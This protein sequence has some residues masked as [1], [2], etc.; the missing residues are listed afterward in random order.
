[1]ELFD[2]MVA[3]DY[4]QKPSISEI[5]QSAWMKEINWELMP[6]LKEEFI[7]R[8][9][10][11]YTNISRQNALKKNNYISNE[12]RTNKFK[13]NTS[14]E[15][16]K[17]PY[18]IS[19]YSENN[20]IKK[21]DGSIRIKTSNKNLANILNNIK[22][23]LQNEGYIKFGGNIKKNEYE[24]TNGDYDFFLFLRKYKK[25]YVNLNYSLKST[26]EY[27]EKFNNLLGNIKQIIEN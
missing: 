26:F 9:Q 16:I 6:L 13:I 4:T 5:R 15:I 19:K 24:G 3:F 21:I 23:F 20:N 18:I 25:G 22:K 10:K 12:F 7:L 17:G 27:I 8:E 2:N 1:M 14:N 11:I